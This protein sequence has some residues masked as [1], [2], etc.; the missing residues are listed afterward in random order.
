MGL[1]DK[2]WAEGPLK[3][4][5]DK[6]PGKLIDSEFNVA[7]GEEGPYGDYQAL[8]LGTQEFID[9]VSKARRTFERIWFESM[10][11]YL[12]NQWLTFDN[13][14]RQFR[15]RHLKKWVPK[16]YTN[17]YA[18]T[19]D[20]IMGV[21]EGIEVRPTAWP[22]TD[23]PDDIASASVAQK[24]L[25]IIDDEI[26][27]K[28]V[29]NQLAPLVV[30]QADAFALPYY[31][32]NDKS[33]GETQIDIYECI[34]CNYQAGPS[35]FDP[36]GV[37]P[38]CEMSVT[39]GSVI[40]TGEKETFP[41][42]RLKVSV[43]SPLEL[44]FHMEADSMQ[45]VM[46]WIYVRPYSI[47][48]V[49]K[50]WPK[51]GQYVEPSK[52]FDQKEG[53]NYSNI[54]TYMTQDS[55]VA[56]GRQNKD[57]TPIY[58]RLKMP[59]D[60]YPDGLVCVEAGD[61]TILEVGPSP[62]FTDSPD[63]NKTYYNPMV[64]FN[65]RTVPSRLYSKTPMFDLLPK[66]KQRNRLE[67]L[68][69]LST[70]KGVYNSWLLPTGSSISNLSGEPSQVIRWTPTGT[71]GAKPEVMNTAPFPGI[72]IEWLQ[73]IDND[74]E[75]IAGTF[76]A[77]K[78]NTPKGVSAGY[79]IQLLTEKSFG[80]LSSVMGG[81]Q[82]GW[83]E[84]YKIALIL[85]K[86]NVT[87]ERLYKIQGEAGTWEVEKFTGSDLKG[88]VDLK[89][90]GGT[91]KPKTKLAEQALVETMTKLGVFDTQDPHQKYAIAELFGMGHM[92]GSTSDD[93]RHT[94]QEW[95]EFKMGQPPEVRIVVDNH[96]IHIMDHQKRAKGSVFKSFDPQM[97]QMWEKHINDHI[98][99]MMMQQGGAAPP[100]EQ[101]KPQGAIKPAGSKANE[102]G[103]QTMN[104][105]KQGGNSTMGN[106][107]AN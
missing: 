77:L 105:L 102:Q 19:A 73:Q 45:D 30:L 21:L 99:V 17:R 15:Q 47:D 40:E 90:E 39:P 31:D 74:F 36:E 32:M 103:D 86:Q 5:Q 58:T 38:Q 95:E 41:Y 22:G 81:W 92:L 53:Q 28:K 94:A 67:S 12:G 65:Y 59:C 82:K 51:T 13:S 75:E 9:E 43:I 101:K 52:G 14:K 62:F 48:L 79:A 104:Q 25:R 42:G 37:C 66:Q 3:E 78:G 24:V 46:E 76:D 80:R 63:G 54:I 29:M 2:I 50:I 4:A 96:M 26:D 10:L 64:H 85:F 106:G 49:K 98:Q 57:T 91:N 83:T 1:M 16:P 61:E 18:S 72:L 84:L 68:I 89:L 69:E 88:S 27:H 55:L 23:D 8:R 93:Y 56:S 6:S 71:N 33:L 60:K 20:T 87:E 11:F 100:P 70:M 34:Y 107:G 44:Y 7:E 35:E 97:Q